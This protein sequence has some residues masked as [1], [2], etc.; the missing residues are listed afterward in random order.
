[1]QTLTATKDVHQNQGQKKSTY[2][3]KMPWIGFAES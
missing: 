3:H 2:I 1:M